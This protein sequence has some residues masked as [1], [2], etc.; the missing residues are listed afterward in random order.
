M[1]VLNMFFSSMHNFNHDFQS[2]VDVLRLQFPKQT[3]LVTAEEEKE[4]IPPAQASI[5]GACHK[6]SFLTVHQTQPGVSV[7]P[8]TWGK[9][10]PVKGQDRAFKKFSR[11]NFTFMGVLDGVSGN[12]KFSKS[13][14]AAQYFAEGICAAIAQSRD[15]NI[16]NIIEK[17]Y[18][19]ACITAS[20]DRDLFPESSNN[21]TLSR[22]ASTTLSLVR[23]SATPNRSGHYPGKYQA[24]IFALGDSSVAV[25][26]R[27]T[28]VTGLICGGSDEAPGQVY[29]HYAKFS[30]DENTFDSF[31]EA[32][33]QLYPDNELEGVRKNVEIDLDHGDFIIVGSDGLWD[34]FK[35]E[36]VHELIKSLQLS[37]PR[38]YKNHTLPYAY[39][40]AE[41]AKFISNQ[42]RKDM[43]FGGKSDDISV[44]VSRVG[45]EG[46]IEVNDIIIKKY[47]D[48]INEQSGFFFTKYK[49]KLFTKRI[50]IFTA[51]GSLSPT[52]LQQ[53]IFPFSLNEAV[54]ENNRKRPKLLDRATSIKNYQKQVSD[55]HAL[56]PKDL[57]A[58]R[59]LDH[60]KQKG[61]KIALSMKKI[62]KQT[63]V[64]PPARNL[65]R[66]TLNTFSELSDG[67]LDTVNS[68]SNSLDIL[69]A[70]A[71]IMPKVDL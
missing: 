6:G 31:D 23:I 4:N 5:V 54:D 19:T 44:V 70:L 21:N 2:Q 27:S 47:N 56:L 20:K 42:P 59:Q 60:K 43:N 25:C 17:G 53:T 35:Q 39:I 29:L 15:G 28:G 36:D 71:D 3:L 33:E 63:P 34:N 66:S 9:C 11:G 57:P 62:Q 67:L 64:N 50:F 55:C 49:K 46:D 45:F 16:E 48:F 40:I 30:E 51:K 26:H 38:E 8:S 68:E 10:L 52:I 41:I 69:A 58:V 7:I 18:Y 61:R 65:S 24:Q 1:K 32:C 13:E 12:P 22:D 37:Y 14:L